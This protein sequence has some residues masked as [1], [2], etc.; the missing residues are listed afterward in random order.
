MLITY[1]V[2]YADSARSKVT[3]LLT[4]GIRL[5]QRGWTVYEMSKVHFAALA[6][7]GHDAAQGQEGQENLC[8]LRV[9]PLSLLPT[10]G[11]RGLPTAGTATWV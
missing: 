6:P 2:E 3:F 8:P 7:L 1:C 11:D 4:P 9:E 10:H 5:I